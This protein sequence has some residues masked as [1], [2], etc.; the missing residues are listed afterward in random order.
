MFGIADIDPN[1]N[2]F[3]DYQNAAQ[4]T[5][6]Y[7]TDKAMEY[8][9]LGL[10]GEAGELA[11]KVK[12]I[13]RGDYEG[14]GAIEYEKVRQDLLSEA[15]DVLWYLSETLRTLDFK[16]SQCAENNIEKL[17]ERKRNNTVKGEGDNR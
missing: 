17:Q 7:P 16:L 13:I 1:G 5:A 12:K 15:G 6:L 11:N 8:L 2:D 3:D 4:K 9:V 14:K 10:C